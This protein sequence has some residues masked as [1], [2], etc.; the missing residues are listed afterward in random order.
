MGAI[1]AIFPADN[2]YWQVGPR[3]QE[4]EKS[5]LSR[6]FSQ[7]SK[8]L[9]AFRELPRW[10][11]RTNATT[12]AGKVG[13]VASS[14]V[15]IATTIFSAI[16]KGNA[17]SGGY[18]HSYN[19]VMQIAGVS[20]SYLKVIYGVVIPLSL[21]DIYRQVKVI[22]K[23]TFDA[24][25]KIIKDIS[26]IGFAASIAI[27]GLQEFGKVSLT[28]LK[29]VPVL[30][31]A[32]AVL[33]GAEFFYHLRS[34]YLHK[35][36]LTYL[37]NCDNKLVNMKGLFREL[38]RNKTEGYFEK[39][40][41]VNGH[42]MRKALRVINNRANKDLQSDDMAIK[43]RGRK[44]IEV[45]LNNLRHRSKMNAM[46]SKMSMI[47]ALIGTVALIIIAFTPLSP[48]AILGFT[49]LAVSAGIHVISLIHD[50]VAHHHFIKSL[51]IEE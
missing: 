20:L 6:I 2:S 33:S 48:L 42:K 44:T 1:P 34:A 31:I 22:R 7:L 3:R 32:S 50:R 11:N 45:T 4:A 8:P 17:A 51:G 26:D 37:R 18:P 15:R 46:E 12:I 41:G 13:S 24:T 5:V 19:K 21:Y 14:L 30:N 47:A 9:T 25:A 36:N 27:A 28:V 49:M 10:N 38:R 43:L 23:E 35:K 40:Y 29:V 16:S 39:R